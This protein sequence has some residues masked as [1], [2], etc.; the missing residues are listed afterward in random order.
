MI[1]LMRLNGPHR[2]VCL[3]DG[4]EISALSVI[5]YVTCVGMRAA[6]SR[7]QTRMAKSKSIE[8]RV[9]VGH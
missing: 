5:S 4:N 2:E 7:I 8:I 3:L 1:R 9:F 6:S